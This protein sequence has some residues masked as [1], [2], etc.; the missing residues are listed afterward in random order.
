MEKQKQFERLYQAFYRKKKGFGNSF[1]AALS[2]LLPLS[3]SSMGALHANK[4]LSFEGKQS[5]SE[6]EWEALLA[7]QVANRK[8]QNLDSGEKTAKK[9]FLASQ[10][11]LPEVTLSKEEVSQLVLKIEQLFTQKYAHLVPLAHV[12]GPDVVLGFVQSLRS[13]A[14]ELEKAKAEGRGENYSLDEVKKLVLPLV[15]AAHD[16][17]IKIT[18]DDTRSASLPFQLQWNQGSFIVTASQT[19]QIHVGDRLV[20]IE[21]EDPLVYGSREALVSLTPFGSA[22]PRQADRSMQNPL[23]E[24]YPLPPICEALDNFIFE[25][26]KFLSRAQAPP[27]PLP[28]KPAYVPWRPSPDM[29]KEELITTR[30]REKLASKLTL[31]LGKDDP[32]PT[33]SYTKLSFLRRHKK[34]VAGDD[35]EEHLEEVQIPWDF[36]A[37][38]QAQVVAPERSESEVPLA[39]VQDFTEDKKSYRL[40]KLPSCAFELDFQRAWFLF[41]AIEEAKEAKRELIVDLRGCNTFSEEGYMGH[42]LTKCLIHEP[43]Y[44][45]ERVVKIDTAPYEELKKKHIDHA[46][47]DKSLHRFYTTL[48]HESPEFSGWRCSDRRKALDDFYREFHDV[49]YS[50]RCYLASCQHNYNQN[51]S[52]S[53]RKPELLP[54]YG[55][56]IS[57]VSQDEKFPPKIHFIIDE[58]TSGDALRFCASFQCQESH[59]IYGTHSSLMLSPTKSFA[60]D[61]PG[62]KTLTLPCFLDLFPTDTTHEYKVYYLD[63]IGLEPKPLPTA[64]F[65]A[66]LSKLELKKESR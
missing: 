34:L 13:F 25:F 46:A 61:L 5:S 8:E 44:G 65:A 17:A 40:L 27:P 58:H 28:Y 31:R 11:P 50:R 51:R 54:I 7:K 48:R 38:Q 12:A 18:F 29:L 14:Q 6:H 10:V 36:D 4:A 45:P 15:Q 53:S 9:S 37:G 62:V 30:E 24:Q 56:P 66:K 63:L 64:P 42:F 20:K 16:E 55:F 32:L 39:L 23:S 43:L 3:A 33:E 21:G 22:R 26:E 35:L 52:D 1:Y 57:P 47:V 60:L 59:P 19:D 2:L 41:E 49:I